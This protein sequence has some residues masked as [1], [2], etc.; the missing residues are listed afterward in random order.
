M[1]LAA[2]EGSALAEGGTKEVEKTSEVGSAGEEG[3]EGSGEVNSL[4]NEF[5]T[6]MFS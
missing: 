1:A 4:V 3:E 2:G 5:C 6:N